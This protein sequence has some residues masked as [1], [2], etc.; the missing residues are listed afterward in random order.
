MS[1]H[2]MAIAITNTHPWWVLSVTPSVLQIV[3]AIAITNS[4]SPTKGRV[5]WS[6]RRGDPGDKSPGTGTYKVPVQVPP[7][8]GAAPPKGAASLRPWGRSDRQ[9]EVLAN[10]HRRWACPVA[11]RPQGSRWI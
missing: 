7:P 1:R 10:A 8:G 4:L 2:A 5:D 11:L 3:M 6:P 9:H